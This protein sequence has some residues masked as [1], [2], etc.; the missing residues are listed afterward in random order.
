DS[1]IH[2]GIRVPGAVFSRIKGEPLDLQLDYSFTLFRART[3][4][5]LPAR[6]GDQRMPGVGWCATRVNDQGSRVVF[7]CM[8]PGER[9]PCVTLA[10]EHTPTHRRNPDV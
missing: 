7:A 5:A 2:Q 4:Y 1:P 10:L 9:P 3:T 6:D 8:Q